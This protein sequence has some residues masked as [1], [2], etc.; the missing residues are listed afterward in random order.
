MPS[1][2]LIAL[3]V[4]PLVLAYLLRSSASLTFLSL[5][6]AALLVNYSSSDSANLLHKTA[7]VS[8]AG[9]E[10]SL[11]IIGMVTLL[12]LL[13][14]RNATTRSKLMLHAVPALC[15]GGLLALLTVPLLSNSLQANISHSL[16]WQNLEK[17]Q[18][19]VVGVGVVTSLILVWLA[20]L[21]HHHPKKHK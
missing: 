18:A 2:I 12:T 17:Y 20:A 13:L 7:N 8:L 3:I 4:G 14:T 6:A 1:V 16:L 5:G 15:A 9:A 19:I 21:T 10:L 11:I